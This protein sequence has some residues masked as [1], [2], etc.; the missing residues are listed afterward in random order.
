MFIFYD[1]ETTGI[2]AAF[3]Q[4]LQFAAILTDKNFK[5]ID[6]FE[7]RCQLLPWVVP[8]PMALIVTKTSPVK[9]NDQTLPTFYEMI[10]SIHEKLESWPVATFIGYNSIAF[11][12]QFLHRAFWQTLHPPYTTVTNGNTRCD[13]LPILRASSHFFPDMFIWPRKDDGRIT[14]KLDQLAPLNG[15]DHSNAHD[16]L[17]DVEATIFLSKLLAERLPILWSYLLNRSIK[18]N[19]TAV[20]SSSAPFLVFESVKGK[21][22]TWFGQLLENANSGKLSQPLVAKLGCDWQ[23]IG[24]IGNDA[25]ALK[26]LQSK[27]AIKKQHPG[28]AV[29]FR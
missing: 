9:L 14:L 28:A 26:I 25:E 23:S 5:E 1:T 4:I 21:S 10:N 15:F 24:C 27:K 8:A 13:I 17:S 12:E 22:Y 3:D 11:D 18:T 16:A 19:A 7:I 6:R 20:V 29:I 2:N